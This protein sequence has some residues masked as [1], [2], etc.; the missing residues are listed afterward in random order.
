MTARRRRPTDDQATRV[1]EPQFEGDE[2]RVGMAVG[3][4]RAA[5]VAVARPERSE[6]IVAISMKDQLAAPRAAEPR[7]PRHV[8]L[9]SLAE[10]SGR[11]DAS[12]LGRLA[13]PRDPRSAPARRWR[14]P[15]GWAAVAL[16]LAGAIAL[17]IW[18]V[19]GR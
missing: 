19:A 9:R 13:P 7:V 16:V 18:L 15:L 6:P 17:A 8:Q 12:R 5:P 1:R 11:N 3:T 14:E 4:G 2:T 10:V